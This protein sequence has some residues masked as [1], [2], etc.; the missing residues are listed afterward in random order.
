MPSC[1]KGQVHRILAAAPLA[2][3]AGLVD[4]NGAAIGEAVP[5]DVGEAVPAD[6]S[7]INPDGDAA[8]QGSG[9]AIGAAAEDL[10]VSDEFPEAASPVGDE[11]SAGFAG[12]LIEE[13]GTVSDNTPVEGAPVET[14]APAE[15]VD[16]TGM[17]GGVV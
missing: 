9:D 17:G 7:D 4:E 10:I 3:N 16:P 13:V 11:V 2:Q 14:V 8:E 5:S 12:S 15:T 6:V 1:N